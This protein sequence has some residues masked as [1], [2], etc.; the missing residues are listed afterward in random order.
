MKKI[1]TCLIFAFLLY[2]CS[3][4]SQQNDIDAS[5]VKEIKIKKKNWQENVQK[6]QN[7]DILLYK[8]KK[9]TQFVFLF[10]KKYDENKDLFH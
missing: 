7:N 10:D 1:C 5:K 4:Q 8:S 3:G 6:M 9:E 2:S